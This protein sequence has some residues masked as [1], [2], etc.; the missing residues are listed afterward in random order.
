MKLSLP[1][2]R[3]PRVMAVLAVGLVFALGAGAIVWMNA[4]QLRSWAEVGIEWVRGL[5]P[6]AFFTA[7]AILPAAAVPL[8]VFTLTAGTVFAPTLGM[9][10]V[11]L[12]VALSLAVN[13]TLTYV[14]AR[15][16]LRPWLLKLCRWLGYNV[17]VVSPEDQVK[18]VVLVRVT[19]GPPYVLQSYLLGLA[20]IP[21]RVYFGISWG[22][23]V[24]YS[25][26]FVMF[27]NALMQGH[28]RVAL[29]AVGLFVALTVG[30][31]WL[32]GR[33]ASK[34]AEGKVAEIT[35]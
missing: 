5:G 19:P 28:A 25:F 31:R 10:V 24:F 27:G 35:D 32:K 6:V 33:V 17:P 13:Q 21:F 4:A 26:A 7:M 2:L 22:I 18:L 3:D 16:V 23:A 20:A 8:S 14:L 12:L 11:L 34:K 30:I 29:A 9:P 15:W 1:S